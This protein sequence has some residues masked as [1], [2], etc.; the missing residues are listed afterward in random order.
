MEKKEK[1]EEEHLYQ[2]F[3]RKP[4]SLQSNT[5]FSLHYPHPVLAQNSEYN[6]SSQEKS[7]KFQCLCS[8]LQS[9]ELARHLEIIKIKSMEQNYVW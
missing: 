1:E 5:E 4:C 2:A 9:F 7:S 6:L 8:L 3:P